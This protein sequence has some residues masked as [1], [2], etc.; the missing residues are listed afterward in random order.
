MYLLFICAEESK[1]EV[2]GFEKM[3]LA[4]QLQKLF[5]W[6]ENKSKSRKSPVVKNPSQLFES[7]EGKSTIALSKEELE[8]TENF[9]WYVTSSRGDKVGP[10]SLMVLKNWS[11]N[12]GASELNIYKMGQTEEHAKPLTAVLQLAFPKM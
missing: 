7:S 4:T 8:D 5:E 2:P 9:Q 6:A 11:Q 1:P 12:P 3:E 10:V